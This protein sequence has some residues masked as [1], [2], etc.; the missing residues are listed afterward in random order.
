MC[1]LRFGNFKIKK[2]RKEIEPQEVLLDSLARDKERESGFSEKKLESPISSGLVQGFFI[3]FLIL[4]SIFLGRIFQFQILEAGSLKSLAEGNKFD[5]LAIQAERGVI[6][7]NG[8]KQLVFNKPSFNLIYR[9]QA[10]PSVLNEVSKILRINHDDLLKKIK[11]S[12]LPRVLVSENLDHQTLVVLEA[13][14]KDLSGFEIENNSVRE[15]VDPVYAHLIGYKRPTGESAGLEGYYDD[16]LKSKPGEI[17]IERDVRQKLI[18][19]QIVSLPQS[20]NSLVLWLDANL[21]EKLSDALES[22][23]KRVGSRAGSAVALDPSTGGILAMVSYPYFDNNLFSQGMSESQWQALQNNPDNPL[24]NRAISGFGYPTGSVIKPLIGIAALEEGVI[25]PET[26][27]YSP[28]EIC[29]KNPWYPDKEDCYADWKY[30]GNTDLRRAIAESVNTFFYQVGGGYKSFKGLGA[31]KIKEW[32]EYFNWGRET[33]VDLPKEGTGILPNLDG[34]W[35]VGDTYHFS[36]GQGPFSIPP[37]QVAT[38]FAGIANGG[39]IFQPHA[40]KEIINENKEVIKTIEPVVLG[41]IPAQEEN[42]EVAR[43]GMRQAVTFPESPSNILN[44]LPVSAAAKTGT[45]QTA[46]ENSYHTWVTVFAPYENPKIVLTV[47]IEN[48]EGFQA[49]ALPAAREVLDWYFSTP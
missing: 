26:T 7:D 49:A 11:E 44:S 12:S 18:S 3:T 17:K 21:Q 6:Y 1:A 48:V 2:F 29:I 38:A 31:R 41:E 45:A 8:L 40:V 30:H 35:R 13:R 5:A 20:G 39:K 24:F 46:K 28:L 15:Y 16:T 32:L 10:D 42:I 25:K 27:I 47:I 23:I 22:S 34:E 33:G 9:G 43:Q 19:R 37:L 36:I 14:I 4:V